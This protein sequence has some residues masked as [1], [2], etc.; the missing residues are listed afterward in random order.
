MPQLYGELAYNKLSVKIGHFYTPVG[1]EVIPSNG[2]FFLSRQLTFYNSEPF[3]HTG[4]LG[5]YKHDDKLQILSGWVAGM[6]TGFQQFNGSSSYLGGFIYQIAEKTTFTYMMIGGNLGWR[7]QGAINSFILSHGWTD[8]LTTVHQFDVLGS[9]NPTNFADPANPI[10]RD[11]TGFIN[12]AFYQIND[13]LKAGV[14][15]E[16]YKADGQS[17][18]TCTYG[19]NYFPCKNL[20]IRPEMRQM[21]SPN[22]E[23]YGSAQQF[24]L[25]NQN[26]FGIDAIF[27]F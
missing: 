9:N 14:R 3:T 21:W 27:T 10:A 4:V 13:Q 7:G 24:G 16:W 17:Y 18:Y 23:V 20:V 2:N 19:V 26:V 8:K 5:T 1:Y 12:Y 6:D 11:S 22:H 25:F 15:G